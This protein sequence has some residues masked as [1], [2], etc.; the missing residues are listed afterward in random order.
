MGDLPVDNTWKLMSGLSGQAYQYKDGQSDKLALELIL[1]DR[2]EIPP[3][4]G[5]GACVYAFL[6]QCTLLPYFD[7]NISNSDSFF[8]SCFTYY[9]LDAFRMVSRQCHASKSLAC[10]SEFLA[11]QSFAIWSRVSIVP[12]LTD[13][14]RPREW[15]KWDRRGDQE[16]NAERQFEKIKKVHGGLARLRVL[17]SLGRQL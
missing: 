3:A 4:D 9:T 2:M 1:P 10:V 15:G 5:V 13:A 17:I 7:N 8:T 16:R 11:P 14:T 12:A 6:D